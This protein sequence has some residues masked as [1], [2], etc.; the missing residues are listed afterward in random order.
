MGLSRSSPSSSLCLVEVNCSFH[1]TSYLH[2][3]LNSD[4]LAPD[5]C[6]SAQPQEVPRLQQIAHS[7]C[8]RRHRYNS[9]QLTLP[10]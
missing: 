10:E 7:H 6:D 1:S 5:H 8:H 2:Y 9:H 4:L 3:S